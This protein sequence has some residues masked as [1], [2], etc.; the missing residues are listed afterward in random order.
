MES[1]GN[2]FFYL[3]HRA[4]ANYRNILHIL[5]YLESFE[6]GE[7]NPIVSDETIKEAI[8]F[9]RRIFNGYDSLYDELNGVMKEDLKDKRRNQI[10]EQ[11]HKHKNRLPLSIGAFTHLVK[12]ARVKEV[13]P[14]IRDIALLR[15]RQIIGIKQP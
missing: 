15:G 7:F 3:Y 13:E 2:I 11:L 5:H 9:T 1:E 12:N 8:A 10:I 6:K 14:I 4:I